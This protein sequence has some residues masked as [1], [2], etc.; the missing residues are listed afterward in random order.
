[1]NKKQVC[2]SEGTVAGWADTLLLLER[3]AILL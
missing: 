3:N 2:G 1:M